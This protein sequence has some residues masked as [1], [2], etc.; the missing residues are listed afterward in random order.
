MICPACKSHMIVVEHNDIELDWCHNCQ[1]VWFDSTEL[2]L[3]FKS[4]NLDGHDLIP[5]N[6]S[7]SPEA[8][9]AEKKRKCPR[10]GR[11]MKKTSVGDR[12]KILI[13]L[14][15]RGHG[16]WFDGGELAQLLKELAEKQPHERGSQPKVISF[17]AEVFKAPAA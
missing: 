5:A 15:R 17:L 14:C 6:I 7:S 1:G 10:C 9:S 16:L 2:E 11:R 8:K 4:M 12:P 3:L 13:D